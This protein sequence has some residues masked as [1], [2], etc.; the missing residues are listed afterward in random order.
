MSSK[1][2]LPFNNQPASSQKGTGTYT[3]PT[4]KY[5]RVSISV[6]GTV[7][8]APSSATA[9]ASDTVCPDSDS[10][11][12]TFDVWVKAGDT[13][14]ATATAASGTT[15]ISAASSG[16]RSSQTTID[17]KHNSSSIGF[18]YAQA[19]AYM[20]STGAGSLTSGGSTSFVWFAQEY[21]ELT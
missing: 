4:G 5:A 17:V 12:H 11:A 21:N 20:Y 15:S 18:F 8:I 14:S 2:I 3:C 10:F 6:S 16:T 19:Q 1:F 13:I 7:V 9:S